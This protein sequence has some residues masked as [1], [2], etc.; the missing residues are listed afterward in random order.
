MLLNSKQRDK[1]TQLTQTVSIF[2]YLTTLNLASILTTEWIIEL[3]N[4]YLHSKGSSFREIE[5]QQY[6]QKLF[7]L[8]QLVDLYG[9]KQELLPQYQLG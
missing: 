9:Q 3:I 7:A 4:N 1:V 8:E 2:A 6:W 5:N